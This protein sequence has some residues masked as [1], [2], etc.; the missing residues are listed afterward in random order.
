MEDSKIST[1]PALITLPSNDTNGSTEVIP[2]PGNVSFDILESGFD[3]SMQ[4]LNHPCKQPWSY[5][6]VRV[7]ENLWHVVYWTSQALTW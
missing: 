6:S 1:T 4:P 3:T 2:T 7:L 5:V